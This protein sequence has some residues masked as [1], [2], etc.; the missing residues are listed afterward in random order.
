VVIRPARESE[1]PLISSLEKSG[2]RRH[3][4]MTLTAFRDIP[5]N[6]P[7]YTRLGWSTL[8]EPDLPPQLAEVRRQERDLGF[9]E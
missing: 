4:R 7:Y 1:L 3:R 5:W 9:D 8:S 6:G 2:E